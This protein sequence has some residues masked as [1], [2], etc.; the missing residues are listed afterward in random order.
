MPFS[1]N[2]RVSYTEHSA[3]ANRLCCTQ[4][5]TVVC[6]AEYA[7]AECLL[8]QIRLTYTLAQNEAEVRLVYSQ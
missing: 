2:E 1:Q 6:A 5:H 7:H 4:H 8:R 3:V